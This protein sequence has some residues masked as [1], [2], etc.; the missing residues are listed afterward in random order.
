MTAVIDDALD[1]LG[2]HLALTHA[3]ELIADRTHVAP[4][5]GVLRWNHIIDKLAGVD[6]RG[7]V[8][9]HG[10]PLA[11]VAVAVKTLAP[12]IDRHP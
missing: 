3:K 5:Q 11:D 2:P 1:I 8:V 9:T 10:L 6:Y 12:L 4:G 7:A